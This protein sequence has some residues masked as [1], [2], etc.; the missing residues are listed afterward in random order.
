[1][2][3][4][5]AFRRVTSLNHHVKNTIS[6]IFMLYH[7]ISKH[8]YYMTPQGNIKN[9]QIPKIHYP[10]Y[11]T[12][13]TKFIQLSFYNKLTLQKQMLLHT[14]WKSFFTIP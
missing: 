3:D 10:F 7:H 2:A 11:T 9:T 5:S 1:M 13:K 14:Q 6:G 8:S 4:F 12:I